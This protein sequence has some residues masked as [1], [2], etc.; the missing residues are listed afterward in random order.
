MRG[1]G[2]RPAQLTLWPPPPAL[3]RLW[4]PIVGRKSHVRSRIPL[5]NQLVT[6]GASR[7]AVWSIKN[8]VAPVH[9]VIYRATAGRI[10]RWGKRSR[11]ILLLTTTGRR[12]GKPRTTPVFFLRDAD[13]YVLCNVRPRSERVNPWVLNMAADPSVSIQV[14]RNVIRCEAREARGA[15]LERYWPQLVALWPSYREHFRRGG[16]RSVFLLEPVIA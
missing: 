14:G 11:N 9:R 3:R 1:R 7:F 8:V 15:E 10:F 13:R 6:L 5:F 12:T 2:C 16:K 4:S